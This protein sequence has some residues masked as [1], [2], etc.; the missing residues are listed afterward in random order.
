[1]D[2]REAEGP[3]GAEDA[4]TILKRLHECVVRS[5]TRGDGYDLLWRALGDA[6]GLLALYS[7]GHAAPRDLEGAP[8]RKA[9]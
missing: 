3:P 4:W 5:L 9:A 7:A 8:S 2:E 6:E 1:M